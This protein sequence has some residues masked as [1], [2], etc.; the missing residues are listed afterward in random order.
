MKY[1]LYSLFILCIFIA[2]GKESSTEPAPAPSVPSISF[3]PDTCRIAVG[4]RGELALILNLQTFKAFG[5]SMRIKYLP[6]LASFND[7]TG[8]VLPEEL[9]QGTVTFIKANSNTIHLAISLLQGLEEQSGLLPL[10]I[11]EMTGLAKGMGYLEIDP[12]ELY[13]YDKDGAILSIPDLVIKNSVV[14]VQ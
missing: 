9:E 6:S 10:G 7:T 14:V 5:V 13:F 4:A 11:L 3:S 8:F 12:D 2:C 1:F